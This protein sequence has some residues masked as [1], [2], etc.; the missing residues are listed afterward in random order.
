MDGIHQMTR[1]TQNSHR[2]NRSNSYSQSKLTNWTP[3]DPYEGELNALPAGLQPTSLYR[4][5]DGFTIAMHERPIHNDFVRPFGCA[6]V[7]EVLRTVPQK[8]LAGLQHIYLLGG[9]KKQERAAFSDRAR[10]GAYGRETIFLYAFPRRCMNEYFT[11]QPRPDI[12]QEYERAGARWTR[13]GKGWRWT[14]DETSLRRF[15]LYDV[16]IH[17]IGH[18]VGRDRQTNPTSHERFAEWFVRTYGYRPGY[19]EPTE[20]SD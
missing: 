20:L 1:L 15:M 8:F 17:E 2:S 18:H 5:E 4:L 7:D 10:W 11:R 14:M 13:E 16:L 9:T 3:Y 19:Q 12:V 6:E